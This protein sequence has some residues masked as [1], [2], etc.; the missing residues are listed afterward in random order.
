[1][2]RKSLGITV[3]LWVFFIF[4]LSASMVSFM[5]IET[6]LHPESHGGNYST[7]WEDALMGVFF[8]E[9]FIVSNS[10][11]MRMNRFPED[12]LPQE[13]QGDFFDAYR[14]GAEFFILVLLEFVAQGGLIRPHGA[15]V[16]VLRTGEHTGDLIYEQ[17]IPAGTGTGIRDEFIR[18]QETGKIL[19]AHIKDR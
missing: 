2:F 13:I 9:G 10:P 6:G 4:P 15:L 8:D 3:F 19:A 17:H 14:G 7:V 12:V 11:V 1:M 16:R 5:V 18:A